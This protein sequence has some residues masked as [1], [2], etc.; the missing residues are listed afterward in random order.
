M[1]RRA[2]LGAG[3]GVA[4]TAAAP[5]VA[6]DRTSLSLV[7]DRADV[8]SALAAR[9]AAVFDGRITLDVSVAGSDEATGFLDTVSAGNADMYLTRQDAFVLRNPAFGLFTA[10][11]GGMSTSELE[12]WVLVSDGRMMWDALAEEFGV[13]CYMAG[14]DGA[15]PL[16]SRTPINELADLLSGPV[17]STGLGL[18]LLAEMGISDGVDIMSGGDLGSLVALEGFSAARMAAS[19]LLSSFPHMTTPNAGRPSAMLA[20]GVNMSRWSGLSETDQFLLERCIMAEHGTQRALALHQNVVAL[21]VAGSS[22]TA[23]EMPEDIWA[24]QIAG[25]NAVMARMFDA[26]N[27]AADAA[28]SYLYFI[29]D[30]AGWSE[31]GETAYFLGRKE[32]LSQ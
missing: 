31:I 22:I 7:T 6:Q 20:V 32:A 2:F 23:H 18:S 1:K 21:N 15:M 5:A 3:L 10:M 30:V 12:S 16:W 25:A 14:D 27:L 17:G 4:A 24:A 28:D 19:G 11:P 29:G 13:R 8:A 9:V 26:G